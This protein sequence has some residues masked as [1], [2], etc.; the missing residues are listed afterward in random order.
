MTGPWNYLL[1]YPLS[2]KIGARDMQSS[3]FRRGTEMQLR[4]VSPAAEQR[5]KFG[6]L[7][8]D[9]AR[10]LNKTFTL[11]QFGD[12]G[13]KL[14]QFEDCAFNHSRFERCY[15]RKAVFTRVSFIG[16]TFTDCRFD[17]AQFSQCQLDYA[18][19]YNCH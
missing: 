9:E 14:A 8:L 6:N 15:F 4:E 11:S 19:F 1:V 17:E 2:E 7:Q 18:E 12:S 5:L 16:C 13:F 10:I 3:R